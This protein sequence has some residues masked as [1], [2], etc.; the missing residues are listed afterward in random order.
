VHK[1]LPLAVPQMTAEGPRIVK[2]PHWDLYYAVIFIACVA[3]VQAGPLT[4]TA[5][6]I[7][8]VA[9]AAMVPWYA[10]VGRPSMTL[11]VS[12]HQAMATEREG[13]IQRGTVYLAGLVALFAVVQS[14]NTN[15]WF[16][17]F[18]VCPQCFLVTTAR[19]GH[20]AE[21]GTGRAHR[22]A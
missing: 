12:I 22:A 10:W 15:A 14:Q 1:D 17:A 3:I 8:S 20:R 7:A 4:A 9:L 11:D 21:R 6:I 2:E 16:L 18:A 19:R 5:R 13:L